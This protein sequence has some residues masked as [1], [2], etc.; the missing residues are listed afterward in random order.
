[1]PPAAPAE[2]PAPCATLHM[3][4]GRVLSLPVL[5][6]AAGGTFLD[7]RKMLNESGELAQGADAP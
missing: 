3:P 1:M 5:T 7:V 6:D 4:D 2:T